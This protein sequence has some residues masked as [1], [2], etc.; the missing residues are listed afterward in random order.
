MGL[1]LAITLTMLT[2]A[3]TGFCLPRGDLFEGIEGHRIAPGDLGNAPPEG[4]SEA[5]PILVPL[6]PVQRRGREVLAV[7]WRAPEMDLDPRVPPAE[8][9]R[10]DAL[11]M[12]LA[13]AQYE[14][15][16]LALHAW[17]DVPALDARVEGLDLPAECRFSTWL[18]R[19][20]DRTD[21]VYAPHETA[22][23][24]GPHDLRAGRTTRLW[25]TVWAAPEAP[26]GVSEGSIVLTSEGRELA[27]VPLRVRVLPVTLPAPPLDHA[28]WYGPVWA[29]RET[30]ADNIPRHFAQIREYG[31][32]SVVMA[33]V[34]PG[35]SVDER[36]EIHVDWRNVDRVVDAFLEAG[37]RG[38]VGVDARAI[39]GWCSNYG[40]AMD[41]AGGDPARLGE[42]RVIYQR[43]PHESPHTERAFRRIMGEL[44][45]R[46]HERDWP[47]WWAYAQEESYNEPHRIHQQRYFTPILRDLGITTYLVSN[48]GWWRPDEVEQL[49][50]LWD[51]RCYSLLTEQTVA[52][53]RRAG[54]ELAGFNL[55][56]G[57]RLTWGM[58]ALRHG[59]SHVSQ[60]AYQFG[61][62]LDADGLFS[63]SA[64]LAYPSA[65]GPVPTREL[66]LYR[67]G[68]DDAR[69]VAALEPAVGE[70]LLAA[71]GRRLP[72]TTRDLLLHHAPANNQAEARAVRMEAFR[73]LMGAEPS[74]DR[75]PP[76]STAPAPDHDHVV[77]D[78]GAFDRARPDGT[79]AA[80]TP[81]RAD[82]PA[83]AMQVGAA[84]ARHDGGRG[85]RIRRHRAEGEE[86]PTYL[87]QRL[88]PTE[89]RRE[90]M[91]LD[92]WLRVAEGAGQV[93]LR[94]RCW[95]GGEYIGDAAR[96]WIV[97]E[98]DQMRVV[99]QFN[100]RA[101]GFRREATGEGR[102]I[103]VRSWGRA[104]AA[105]TA[106]EAFFGITPRGG[107]GLTVDFDAVDIAVAPRAPSS[108]LPAWNLV[109]A[110][111]PVVPVVIIN[112]TEAPAQVRLNAEP[113]LSA[114]TPGTHLSALPTGDLAPGAHTLSLVSDGE[115][116]WSGA[117]FVQ[118]ADDGRP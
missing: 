73:L 91:R 32:S 33:N 90:P 110:G 13:R 35:M 42:I 78:N 46:A 26:P 49:G 43:A 107:R 38:P 21:R 39:N 8:A 27:R 100:G 86:A 15:G 47:R 20:Q 69:A 111:D 67:A 108:A 115:E 74:F 93:Y 16:A 98:D 66:V 101:L 112:G 44:A 37:L 55:P 57:A 99:E 83:E 28:V 19:A 61:N 23:V 80:W 52:A 84:F 59:M 9:E 50:D 71:V 88:D 103:H 62:P 31:L 105:A 29:W 4:W 60:W 85:L 82:I 104:P 58:W 77:V 10:A 1:S 51:V 30:F 81:Q 48:A 7:C 89:T 17:E 12:T 94:V 109:A 113:W 25:L 95:E 18:W 70:Q 63:P 117:F 6:A 2:C 96:V 14:A 41:Q 76:P 5:P 75:W 116:T 114:V 87:L 68:I 118:P 97:V 102:W 36:G 3:A 54:R 22:L 45:R 64:A 11:N 53:T 24:R 56:G 92:A 79:P 65:D 72:S 40:E 34:T 106:V